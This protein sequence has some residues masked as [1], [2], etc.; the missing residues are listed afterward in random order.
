MPK[1]KIKKPEFSLTSGFNLTNGFTLVEVLVAVA[2]LSVSLA[3]ASRAASMSINH[4][5]QIKQRILADIVAQNQ[6]ALH[7]AKDEWLP[8]GSRSGV[9]NQAGIT[10]K[11]KEEVTPTPNPAF[12][13]IVVTVN[14]PD[15]EKHSLRKLTGFMV[16]P[17]P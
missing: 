6:L 9:S 7:L 5:Q 2:I 13:K 3:A 12:M 8:A 17:N 14:D 10:F 1:A 4:S 16:R 11:W 15:D